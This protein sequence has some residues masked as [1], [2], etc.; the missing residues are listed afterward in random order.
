MNQKAI[1]Y[2]SYHHQNTYNLIKSVVSEKEY[3]WVNLLENAKLILNTIKQLFS[4]RVFMV[5]GCMKI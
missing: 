5:F 1:I 3:D 2:T 4:H